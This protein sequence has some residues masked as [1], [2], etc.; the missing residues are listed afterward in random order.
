M[1]HQAKHHQTK[2]TRNCLATFL[3]TH[4]LLLLLHEPAPSRIVNVASAGQQFI[5][6]NDNTHWRGP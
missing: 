4:R 2:L 1:Y 6:Y 5:D 3:L